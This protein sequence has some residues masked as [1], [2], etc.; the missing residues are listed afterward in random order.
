MI[1]ERKDEDHYTELSIYNDGERHPVSVYRV[2]CMDMDIDRDGQRLTPTA[3]ISLLCSTSANV[4]TAQRLA[5]EYLFV[6]G[7]AAA[8]QA[9]KRAKYAERF[10][11]PA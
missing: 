6:A 7:A 5:I 2:T 11:A 10:G 4:E 3:R 1:I 9:E 8:L